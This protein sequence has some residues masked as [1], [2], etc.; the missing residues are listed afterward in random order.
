VGVL[1]AALIALIV[2]VA[3]APFISPHLGFLPNPLAGQVQQLEQEVTMLRRQIDEQVAIGVDTP[4]TP[5]E[6]DAL[7]S[8]IANLSNERNQL[9]SQVETLSQEVAERQEDLAFVEQ[10]LADRSEEYAL[11]EESFEDLQNQTAIVQARQRG[12]SSEVDRLT[13]LVGDLEDANA[14][15]AATK[16]ALEH[17]L[18]RLLVQIRD[19]LPLTPSRYAHDQRVADVE[20]LQERVANANW[21]TPDLIQDYTSIYLREL[22]IADQEVYFFA[23]MPVTDRLGYRTQKWAEA[24]MLGNRA[25]YFRTLDGRN[26]GIYS[27]T[28]TVESPNWAVRE[29]VSRDLQQGIEARIFEARVPGFEDQLQQLAQ[30]E[31]GQEE[32]TAWQRA[33]GSL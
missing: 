21:V 17:N 12:L 15:R 6:R 29:N 3:I 14:R 8:E 25:V 28:G 33:F 2:G 1:I 4:I 24:L 31:V 26:I 10:D 13:N 16:D 19:S 32:G 22:E 27:N 20:M 9:A 5:E 7:Q 18:D 30:R 23:R 11:L